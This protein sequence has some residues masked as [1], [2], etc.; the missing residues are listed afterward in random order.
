M[1]SREI[2]VIAIVKTL[3]LYAIW[4]IWFSHPSD[5]YLDADAIERVLLRAPVSPSAPDEE[6]SHARP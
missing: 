2:I 3:L 4:A 6:S 5:K 1:L